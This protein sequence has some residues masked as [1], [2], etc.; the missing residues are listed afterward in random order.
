MLFLKDGQPWI[1]LG[2]DNPEHHI[3][4]VD[5]LVAEMDYRIS[6]V[7]YKSD[8]DNFAFATLDIPT[9]FIFMEEFPGTVA[10]FAD[11]K[12]KKHFLTQVRRI[13]QESAKAGFRL[14][15]IAQKFLVEA[16]L[17][18]ATRANLA[19]RVGMR[20]PSSADAS[21]LFDN[22]AETVPESVIE[23]IPAF[24]PGEGLISQADKPRLFRSHNIAGLGGFDEPYAWYLSE[25]RR[26]LTRASE[27]PL[28]ETAKLRSLP[29][30]FGIDQYGE[31]VVW[32]AVKSAYHS[33]YQ[34]ASRAGK[35][36]LAFQILNQIA[37]V[38]PLASVGGCD[39]SGLLLRPFAEFLEN[40]EGV[41]LD[42]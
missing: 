9:V 4:V 35:S 42:A 37:S 22:L 39:P 41:T 10:S 17:D 24:S 40:S 34:A 32:D 11:A 19:L 28:P 30:H 36:A 15:L 21:L 16:G 26:L 6:E 23:R 25:I 18:S 13:A 1:S 14:S 5:S 29:L 20:V 27:L 33:G 8:A 3:A 12:Q 2:N 31:P 38:F 7:L